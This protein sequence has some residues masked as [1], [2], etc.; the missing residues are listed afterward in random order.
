MRR[1]RIV[2]TIVLVT[3]PVAT[4]ITKLVFDHIEELG[5]VRCSSS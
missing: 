2:L 5:F 1:L 3:I 4:I